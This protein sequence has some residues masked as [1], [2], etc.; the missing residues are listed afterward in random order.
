MESLTCWMIIAEHGISKYTQEPQA[1]RVSCAAY[2]TE[3]TIGFD[4]LEKG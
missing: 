3:W 2:D 1:E 4:F